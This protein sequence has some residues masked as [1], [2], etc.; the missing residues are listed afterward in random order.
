MKRSHAG[1]V[2]R[3][4]E[5]KYIFI[6]L[7]RTN[8][9]IPRVIRAACGARFNHVAVSL[10]PDLRRLYSFAR[11][12]DISPLVGGPVCECLDRY[13]RGN[14]KTV[15]AA[16]FAIRVSDDGYKRAA[17]AVSSV[18]ADREYIY[19]LLS[20]ISMPITGGFRT[21]KAFSCSE[22]A[23][24]I[25]RRAGFAMGAP[26]HECSPDDI[27]RLLLAHSGADARLIYYG[28]IRGCLSR[29]RAD[30]GIMRTFYFPTLSHLAGETAYF[31]YETIRRFFDRF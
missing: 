23:A 12:H 1:L 13:T 10:T 30:H 3:M 5:A 17:A 29:K 18:F 20:V 26:P 8:G 7:T 6:L 24:N 28:D 4:T 27:Y 2:P 31:T 14:G 15:T 9:A 19:N 21:Y 11:L 25:L 22:F 16:L